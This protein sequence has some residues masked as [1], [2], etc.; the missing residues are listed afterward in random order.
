MLQAATPTN[1]DEKSTHVRFT[2]LAFLC[3]L[4]F[5]TYYDRQCLVR[6]QED[7]KDS[8]SLNDGQMGIIFGAFWFAYALFEIPGGWMGDR[9]GARF[10]LTRIVLA[11]SLFT[12]LTGA[13]T[14]FYTLLA[15]RLLFGAGEAGAYPNMAHVQSRWLPKVERARA[16]GIL[17][18]CARWGLAF[19]PLIFG[20]ITRGVESLQTS[21]S[22]ASLLEWFVSLPSW[23]IGFFISGLLG[24]VWCL[25]FYPWFRDEPGQKKSVGRRELEHIH[26]GRGPIETAHRMDSQIWGKLFSSMSLWAIAVYYVCGSFGWSF[27]VSWMPRYLNDVHGASPASWAAY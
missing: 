8:L 23:R 20:S 13:A 9:I 17:W 6:A 18:L 27:F 3:V 26:A 22:G 24:I 19:A 25:A 11:W 21:L 12:A 4:S 14:G 15:Y 16:G 10:T 2:V 1:P 5:L 7:L